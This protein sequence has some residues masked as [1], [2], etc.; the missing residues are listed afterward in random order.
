MTG[1][2]PSPSLS[3]G[4]CASLACVL[5]ASAPKPGN[6]HPGAEF[7]DLGYAEFVA[8][9]VAIGP[10]MEGACHQPLG[11]TVLQAIRAT[12]QVVQTNTNLGAVLLLSPLAAVP[13]HEPLAAGVQKVLAGLDSEDA[14][15]VYEAI[16]WARP[17]GLG[18]RER[19]DV[20]DAPPDNLLEAM[21][22]A[23]DHDLVA[24]QY[25]NGFPEVLHQAAP[26][27]AEGMQGGWSLPDAVVHAHLRLMAAN[28]DSLIL[29]KCGAEM[30]R[31]AAHRAAEVLASGTPGQIS[32]VRRL[33]EFDRWLRAD[34]H[35][36]NPG[37]TAD[38][39]AAG[40]FVLLRG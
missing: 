7:E 13:R 29:R 19:F 10:A 6:V 37:T 23:A 38:L 4:Q 27:L 24:R 26:W 17:G 8:S 28:G 35:R 18:R 33:A 25:A 22:A 20:L 16:R 21:A 34:G 11:R 32:Y 31:E 14:R 3:I 5:E 39:L 9:A 40:L 1:L 30:S 2:F 36:R 12:H 15:Q